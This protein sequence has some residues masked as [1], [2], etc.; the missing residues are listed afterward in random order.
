MLVPLRHLLESQHRTPHICLCPSLALLLFRA[1]P[2]RTLGPVWARPLR[3]LGPVWARPPQ[4]KTQHLQL[5]GP[6]LQRFLVPAGLGRLHVLLEI[7]WQGE[8]LQRARQP[9]PV[10]LRSVWRH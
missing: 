2:L 3:T 6:D 7:S 5:C 1:R 9:P 10:V 4:P 8:D